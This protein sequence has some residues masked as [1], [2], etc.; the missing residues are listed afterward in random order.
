[1]MHFYTC[2]VFLERGCQVNWKTR[3]DQNESLNVK[4]LYSSNVYFR[5][6]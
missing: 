1:M 3:Q 5:G 2:N 4:L 6:Q